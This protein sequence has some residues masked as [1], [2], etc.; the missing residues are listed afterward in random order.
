MLYKEKGLSPSKG[1][2]ISI[3]VLRIVAI[4]MIIS[5][6]FFGFYSYF[7]DITFKVLNTNISGIIFGAL[8]IYLGIRNMLSVSKLKTELFNSDLK[9]SWQN[10]KREK[11]VRAK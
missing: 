4:L 10:F 1:K 9:F 11:K 3:I 8:V 6:V 2:K 5:G 7:N